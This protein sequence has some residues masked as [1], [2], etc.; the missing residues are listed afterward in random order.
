MENP[1]KCEIPINIFS[2]LDF[3][4]EEVLNT[5][6]FSYETKDERIV[7][8]YTLESSVLM[9]NMLKN[10]LDAHKQGVRPWND[11][12]RNEVDYL[13]QELEEFNEKYP[14]MFKDL[15]TEDI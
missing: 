7:S 2:V 6:E 12:Y 1:R 10:W 9:L 15:L 11:K 3:I 4:I 5:S 13:Y 14:Q 8:L